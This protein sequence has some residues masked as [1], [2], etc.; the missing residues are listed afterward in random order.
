MLPAA[1]TTV[2]ACSC[3][4]CCEEVMPHEASVVL[5]A[6]ARNTSDLCASSIPAALRC[7]YL[8]RHLRDRT[9]T[10]LGPQRPLCT[11]HTR[12]SLQ[13]RQATRTRTQMV[14]VLNNLLIN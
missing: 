3:A 10:P 9:N 11:V 8:G 12:D 13:H 1:T 4:Q 6:A 7:R 5:S 14:H 2:A